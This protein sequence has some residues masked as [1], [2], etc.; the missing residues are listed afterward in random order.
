MADIIK[1]D[2]TDPVYQPD[3]DNIVGDKTL[4]DGGYVGDLLTLVRIHL[5]EAKDRGELREEDAGNAYAQ[6]I[7]ASMKDAIDFELQYP[8]A[9]LELCYLQ[10]QIDKLI[11]DCDNQTLKTESDIKVNEAQVDKMECDCNNEIERT[12]STIALNAAQ[13][14]KLA[15]DCCNNSKSTESKLLV[16]EAQIDKMIC[17]CCNSTSSTNSKIALDRAQEEKVKC[18]C[19]NETNI[20]VSKVALNNKQIAGIEYTARQKL[21]DAQ[22]VAWAVVFQDADLHTLPSS[23]SENAINS[24]YKAIVAYL[25]S[26]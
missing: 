4:L 20:A 2:G 14:N 11:C 9:S 12:A 3:W 16:D 25:E 19:T 8:K 24:S 15:C 23:L 26:T 13:E 21:Y 17:D 18:D 22:L 7:I 6:A 1:C 5:E 10:A